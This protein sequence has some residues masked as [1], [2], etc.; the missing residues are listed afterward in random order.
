L[1][2]SSTT[3]AS[4][5]ITNGITPIRTGTTPGRNRS[6]YTETQDF[7]ITGAQVAQTFLISNDIIAT[8]VGFFITAK[9]AA[10]DIHVALC[11]VT[12]GQPDMEKAVAKTIYPHAS[13]VNGWNTLAIQP[14]FLKKGKRYAFVFISNA[15]HKVGMT[16]GQ[17]YLDGT[18]FTSTD[19]IYSI[20]DLTKDMM[21]QV[22]GAKFQSPQVAIEFAPINL[23]GGFRN[24][25]ILTEMWVP[26]SCQL[27]WEIRPN[28]TG[29]WLPL[30]ND[31]GAILATAPPLAQ[32]RARFVG[33]R[34]MQPMLH[35]TGSRVKVW[36]PKTALKHISV[37]I[38]VPALPSSA[39][40]VTVKVL[41]EN[42][43]ET[44][45]DHSLVLRIG[46]ANVSP[47]SVVTKLLDADAKRYQRTY[48]FSAAAGTTS[49]RFVQDGATT[50]AQLTYHVA[51]LVYYTS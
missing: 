48:T 27:F 44:P 16:S 4:R 10:E 42:F 41:L 40:N 12:A 20:G 34:D 18:F 23:D 30:V 33:T 2:A 9:G 50:A 49:L 47:A 11:E 6:S 45:N 37:P 38:T 15:N 26:D 3:A 32:F 21:L 39:N 17:S 35:L 24:I 28:G 1:L 8:K 22:W 51:E 31:N 25:D 43:D 36:R 5:A 19:G 7:T 13:I 46:G 14:T 29:E